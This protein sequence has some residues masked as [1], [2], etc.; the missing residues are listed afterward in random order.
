MHEHART[1]PTDLFRMV[2][3]AAIGESGTWQYGADGKRMNH[4]R[5]DP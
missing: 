5:R 4:G 1:R 3:G 2:H